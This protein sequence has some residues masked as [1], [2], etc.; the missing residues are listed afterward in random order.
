MAQARTFRVAVDGATGYLG[1]HVVAALRK[2]NIEVRCI[3][4]SGARPKDR[5]FLSSIGAEVVEASL[6]NC[7]TDLKQALT[8]CD[9]AVHLIGSIAPRRGE[10]LENLHAA[11]TAN[12]VKASIEVGVRK[13]V[14]VTALGTAPDA[15]ST[16]HKT[17]FLAEENVRNS[18]IAFV[19]YRPSLII[20]K[21]V[22]NRDSKL[23]ARYR[24]LIQTRPKVP[25]IGNGQNK[26]QPIFVADLAD[27]IVRGITEDSFDNR[28]FE[29]GGNEIVTMKEFVE[30]MIRFYGM[31]K[32]VALIPAGLAG[33]LAVGC[34]MFQSVPTVSR[35]QIK[36]SGQDNI[37]RDNA[38]QKDFAITPTSVDDALSTYKETNTAAVKGNA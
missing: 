24:D 32:S 4:H 19:I 2:K 34:E 21:R 18:G 33:I 28:T 17:K 35:D 14:Q 6:E 20:G 23:I 13:I 7:G 38:L 25:V 9:V 29:L 27:A 37:C 31:N 36:L 12:L 26:V 11:Q 10:S 15:P 8:G 3:V 5:E 16:Y 22:G 30:R 1:N